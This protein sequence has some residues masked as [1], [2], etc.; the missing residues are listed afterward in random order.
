MYHIYTQTQ[1]EMSS[2]VWIVHVISAN[3]WACAALAARPKNWGGSAAAAG[4]RALLLANEVP[5][6]GHTHQ[7][8]AANLCGD[9]CTVYSVDR[10]AIATREGR[11]GD[12]RF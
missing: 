5:R 7:S 9:T 12:Q 4:G 2:C 8:P 1:A 11:L 10:L 3:C 6:Y